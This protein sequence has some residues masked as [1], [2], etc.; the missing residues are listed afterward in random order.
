[1]TLSQDEINALMAAQNAQNNE[2]NQIPPAEDHSE[3]DSAASGDMEYEEPLAD[4]PLDILANIENDDETPPAPDHSEHSLSSMETDLL[5]EVG[6]ICMGSVATT[7][8]T[9]LDRR[10]SI[11]TPKVSVH[12]VEEIL[13]NYRTPFIVVEVQY[14]EGIL[15]KN[16]FMLKEYDAAL[17]TDL[18]MGGEGVVEE[19]IELNELHMSAI[20][21]IMNQMIGAS[22][23]ALSKIVGRAINISPPQSTHVSSLT[24]SSS[25]MLGGEYL[26]VQISFEMEIEGLLNSELLQ[27]LPYQLAKDLANKLYDTEKSKEESYK[28]ASAPE[29]VSEPAEYEQP[30]QPP[31]Y[32]PPPPPQP[33]A[34]QPPQPPAYQPPLPYASPS[35][36]PYDAVPYGV[37]P[38]YPYPYPQP[39]IPPVPPQPP[40]PGQLID[41]R[42]MQYLPFDGGASSAPYAEINLVYDIPLTVSVEL[43]KTKKEI[44][45]I[46]EFGSGTVV[47]LDKLAGD[48]VEIMANGKL[49]AKGEVVV[50]EENY[51]VRITEVLN[52]PAVKL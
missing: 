17:I 20:S 21:E 19:P 41:V 1:M 23:T 46:L 24:A 39:S 47:V 30:P 36:S 44:S 22:A 14:T 34:Y 38:P 52:H 12:T 33:P 15:G 4:I 48:P 32:Q 5:G 45:E 11:T 37:Q 9:L 18:L 31:A 26:V 10:V 43:G 6:N 7:M 50:I 27:L 28:V 16:L 49:I 8:Y 2:E 25:D 3:A 13:S 40:Q 29:S 42:P 35:P 51:G